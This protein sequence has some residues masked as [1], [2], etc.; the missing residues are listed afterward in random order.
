MQGADCRLL[1][2]VGSTERLGQV[3]RRGFGLFMGCA[4]A[5]SIFLL[6]CTWDDDTKLR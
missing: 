1:Q 6:I 3:G 4:W 5:F 2:L